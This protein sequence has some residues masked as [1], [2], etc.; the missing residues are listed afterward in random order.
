MGSVI[1]NIEE[2]IVSMGLY[3]F[4]SWQIRQLSP[5]GH[6]LCLISGSFSVTL[7]KDGGRMFSRVDSQKF[8]LRG[9]GNGAAESE[10]EA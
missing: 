5:I 6:N 1:E 4:P 10:A 2:C 7:V 3:G 8:Y 9:I